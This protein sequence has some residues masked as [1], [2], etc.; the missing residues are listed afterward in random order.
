VASRPQVVVTVLTDGAGR[1]GYIPGLGFF[2]THTL[3]PALADA[4]HTE[5]RHPGAEAVPE[6]R[7]RPST[8]LAAFVRHRD[9]GCRFPGCA[10]PWWCCD[11]D[12]T[13][14]W[15]VGPTHAS[16]LKLLCRVHHLLKT[17]WVG[18]W[19]DEQLEDGTVIWTSPTGHRYTT[20]P[21][22]ALF[23]PVLGESTGKLILPTDIPDIPGKGVSM[24]KR[25]MS[26]REEL[27]ARIRYLRN[28]NQHILNNLPPPD[29]PPGW[30]DP[31]PF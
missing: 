6:E 27:E 31:P 22:G 8:G 26:R 13:V 3:E 18:W 21:D 19:R 11:V 1:P 29:P 14:P 16:N 28:V 7:Y 15:P 5:V 24:P 30:N 4:T 20:K 10:V 17:F 12:H 2:D 25:R 9:M 23:F